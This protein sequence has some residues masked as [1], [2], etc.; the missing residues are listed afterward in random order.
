MFIWGQ[1]KSSELGYDNPYTSAPEWQLNPS[2]LK[3]QRFNENYQLG[4][5]NG[6]NGSHSLLRGGVRET[7]V[8]QGLL[9]PID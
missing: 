3:F 4:S 9:A 1:V 5:P 6:R 2:I 7:V 8:G